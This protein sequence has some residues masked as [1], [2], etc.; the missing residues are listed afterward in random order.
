MNERR[1]APAAERNKEPILAV[2]RR[3]LPDSGLVLEIARRDRPA[4]HSLC[5]GLP[6]SE[7]QPSDPDSAARSSIDAWIA[8]EGLPNVR[9]P[10][11]LDVGAETWPIEGAD[12]VLCIN[13]I[14]ISPWAA[15]LHLM[16]GAARVLPMQG[17]LFLYGPFRRLDRQTAPSNEAFDAQLRWQNPDWGLRDLEA[18]VSV[19]E[20]NGLE[21][22]EVTEMPANNLSV[23]FRRIQ[24]SRLPIG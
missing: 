9:P 21:L 14:H 22:V 5:P 10:L 11:D 2:L 7:W 18:V 20:K 4:C 15:T 23:V 6:D 12:A 3:V 16:A 13:M 17:V 8:H 19:A 24:R 1:T